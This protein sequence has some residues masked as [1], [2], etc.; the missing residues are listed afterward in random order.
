[1]AR[2]RL[3]P[4]TPVCHPRFTKS[5]LYFSAISFKQRRTA[6]HQACIRERSAEIWK[7]VIL[8]MYLPATG[9]ESWHDGVHLLL[10]SHGEGGWPKKTSIPAG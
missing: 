9:V 8:S 1:M 3:G 10:V 6:I 7:I 2:N 5:L 4:R